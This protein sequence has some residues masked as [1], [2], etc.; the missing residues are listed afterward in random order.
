MTE[1]RDPMQHPESRRVRDLVYETLATE[2]RA[3]SV[4]ELARRTG[5]EPER[6]QELLHELADAHALVLSAG[7]D[8]IRMAHPF[9]AAPMAFVL[10][11]V[12]GHD[13]RRWWGGCAWDSFGISAALKLEVRIDTACPQCGE[14]LSVDAGPSTP[15]Q[16]EHAVRFPRPAA[17]WWEDVVGTCTMIRLFC[18]REHAEQWTAEH[19]PG[20]GYVAGARTVWDLAQA[21]Y[22]DRI[23]ADFTPHTREHNQR[24]LEERGLAGEF[25]E[26]P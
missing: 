13:D 25:W 8:R 12:D 15:P 2:G 3:P 10:T 14:H 18:T 17:E 9:S 24:L 1:H 11:P 22:G 20:Q 16:G 21:W 5:S 7:G 6:V 4:G 26:L 23:D 19:A